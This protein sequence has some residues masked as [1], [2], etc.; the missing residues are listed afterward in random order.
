MGKIARV[1][2]Y[3][4][5]GCGGTSVA[6]AELGAAGVTHDRTFMAIGPDGACRTQRGDPK[7]AAVRPE[8][9]EGGAKLRLRAPGVEDLELDVAFDGPRAEVAVFTWLGKGVDQG[10]PA[11]DWFSAV[12]GAPSRLVRVS[13]EHQ[14]D[15][16]AVPGTAGFAD[17][18]AILL[19]SLSSLDLLNE[20][21]CSAGGEPVP[22]ERFRPNLVVSG[23]AEPHLEDRVREL[24]AGGA[25]L[26]FAKLC[27]RCAVPMVDQETGRRA[28][29]EPIR[30]LARYRRQPEGGVIFG[31]KAAVLEPGQLAVGDEVTVHSWG[32]E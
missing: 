3:P 8:V 6:A 17:S 32:E 20:R 24:A 10:D 30:S 2:Y 15:F 28:G 27:V 4:V 18:G 29:P 16:G 23:W 11:A 5:K 1:T 14:R 22:M 12:L 7:L 31:M 9:L 19:L 13:P 26:G 21:I 25:R